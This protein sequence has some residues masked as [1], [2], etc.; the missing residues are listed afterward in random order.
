M[1]KKGHLHEIWAMAV[2]HDGKFVVT[3]S[4]DK[5][6]RLWEKTNEP[7]VIE[8]ERETEKDQQFEKEIPKEEQIIAGETNQESGLATIKTIETLKSAEKVIES[9]NIYL[10]E[11]HKREQ[12]RE[13][14]AKVPTQE[15]KNKV[16]LYFRFNLN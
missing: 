1:K 2:S 11:C 9:L 7:L 8:D 5:S 6:M 10:E 13:A 16:I 4:H 12:F 15:E 3:G 14:Q